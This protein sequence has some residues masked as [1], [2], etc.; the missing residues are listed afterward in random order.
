[1]DD[2][3]EQIQAILNNPEKMQ[4]V[5]NL[6]SSLGIDPPDSAS[7]RATSRSSRQTALVE[8]LL[9][10]LRPARRERLQRAIQVAQFSNLGS[11][12]QQAG[13]TASPKEE[14]HV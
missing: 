7:D 11:L 10:Y 8:A 6:A 9:P 5:M 4:Q 14:N 1:M 2:L 3:G 13:L 12:L